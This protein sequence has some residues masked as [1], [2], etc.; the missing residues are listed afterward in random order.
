MIGSIGGFSGS[1]FIMIAVLL[2]YLWFNTNP[3]RLLMGDAGSRALGVFMAILAMQTHQPLH[4]LYSASSSSSTAVPESS[5][6]L[7]S[8]SFI[9]PF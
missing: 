9:Y 6:Y 3:S 1:A 5:K 8:G 4:T 2:A 7:S